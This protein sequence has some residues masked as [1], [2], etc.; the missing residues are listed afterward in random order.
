MAKAFKVGDH[1]SWNSEAG[2]VSGRIVRVHTSDVN[3]KGYVHHASEGD[4]Q[5]EIKATRPIT[6]L[7]TKVGHCGCFAADAKSLLMR[8]RLENGERPLRLDAPK[9]L[10]L[11]TLRQP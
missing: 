1:V 4:P 5:Y 2:W 8:R 11:A 9:W 7:C 10:R 3:Y 6:S